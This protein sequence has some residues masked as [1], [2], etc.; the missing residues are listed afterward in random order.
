MK[1]EHFSTAL[2]CPVG[3]LNK[4]NDYGEFEKKF[5][6]LSEHIHID[7][8]Y[9]ETYRCGESISLD[10]MKKVK[11]FFEGIGIRTSGGITAAAENIAGHFGFV[12]LCYSNAD[13]RE[14]LSKVSA[15]TA[16]LFDEVILDDFYF[17][18]C[19]CDDC[20]RNKGDLTWSE[21]RIRR[22]MEISE[23]CVLEP[24]RKA[25]PHVKV[26]IK[27]PNWY[28]SYQES[29]Y[30]PSE[31]KSIFD[32]IYTGTETRNTQY[33]QQH[34]PAYLSYFLMRYMENIKPGG[35]GGGWFDAFEC[36]ANPNIYTSQAYLTLYSQPKE[37]TLFCLGLL[38]HTDYR[39]FVPMAGFALRE[40]DR[41]LCELG[42]PTGTATYI[43]YHS[44]GEDYLHNYIGML[45]IPLEP[46]PEYPSESNRIFLTSNAAEDPD[47]IAK[48]KDSLISGGN[49][50]VTSGF[51]EQ[52]QDRGFDMIANVRVD[53]RKA[54]IRQAAMIANDLN[55][56]K[57]QEVR[58]EIMLPWLSYRTNDTWL[59]AEGICD[60]NNVP[61][62]LGAY[63]GKGT[64]M[65]LS[66]PDDF[67]SLY[68]LPRN[69]LHKMRSFLS[70]S[71]V[72]LDAGAGVTLY[73]Y[74]N[75]TFI[76]HSFLPYSEMVTVITDRKETV[77]QDLSVDR[78][79]KGTK[80][81]GQTLFDIEMK[82]GTR[83]LL[84]LIS[85]KGIQT[86]DHGD[87]NEKEYLI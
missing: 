62:L 77:L 11:A 60:D 21:F 29:G 18:N 9:L 73:T 87:M 19:K 37:V 67:G 1:Y 81:D 38:L 72:Y 75:D 40:G 82:P 58:G 8:V 78:T 31:Q 13:H 16:S 80:K 68:R 61:I 71:P 24:A 22:M 63:Y 54:I 50:M 41:M 76:L 4:I 20:I 14:L 33:T 84:R 25:N 74:D 36:G 85:S 17:D 35:N 23:Q 46:F 7:K 66:V 6:F 53:G 47:I 49:V 79:L 69:V 10:R 44:S 26:I 39:M 83:R 12:S 57:L 42:R 32:S 51:V 52:M 43:P 55:L 56:A 30:N 27:Y 64:L 86:T 70:A 28:E 2:Y 48:I 34:I 45:G 15:M 59:L 5:S 65:I 3:D